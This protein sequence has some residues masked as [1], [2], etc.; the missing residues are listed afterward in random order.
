MTICVTVHDKMS[1]LRQKGAGA[2]QLRHKVK[3][4]FGMICHQ[5][6]T[7][8]SEMEGM[9]EFKSKCYYKIPWGSF[10]AS[11]GFSRIDVEQSSESQATLP[12]VN[13]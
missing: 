13:V 4:G 1:N 3:I 7:N 6:G 9:T 2:R 5:E 12:P 8:D 10:Q 11:L